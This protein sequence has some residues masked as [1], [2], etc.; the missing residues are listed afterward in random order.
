MS[1][2]RYVS[3]LKLKSTRLTCSFPAFHSLHPFTTICLDPRCQ[4][5]LYTDTTNM[6]DRKL[7]EELRL[8]ITVFSRAYGAVPGYAT[9]RYCRKIRTYCLAKTPSMLSVSRCRALV[10]A[11]S[12]KIIV[13]FFASYKLSDVW[14]RVASRILLFQ[15]IKSL[16]AHDE[17]NRV[18]GKKLYCNII[19]Q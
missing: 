5:S 9:S 10:N 17:D 13:A 6:Q 14:V 16:Y 3:G 12:I 4:R 19:I 18:G 1:W 11:N 15:V 7:V 8:P 2:S